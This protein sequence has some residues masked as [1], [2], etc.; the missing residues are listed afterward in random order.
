[1]TQ[2]MVSAE[3]LRILESL[4][5]ALETIVLSYEEF[6][7]DTGW[8]HTEDSPMAADLKSLKRK[9]GPGGDWQGD[10]LNH[11][12]TSAMVFLVVQEQHIQALAA[13][14]RQ[15]LV[16]FS[17]API[18]RSVL[19]LSGRVAWLLDTRIDSRTRAARGFLGQIED[20]T[21]A[22]RTAYALDM[23]HASKF[24]QRLHDVRK[25]TAPARFD[26]SEIETMKDGVM[27]IRKQR[28]PGLR[29]SLRINEEVHQNPWNAGGMYDYLSNATH[30][31]LYTALEMFSVD[32]QTSS[33]RM[34]SLHLENMILPYR[35][36]R[37]SAQA[38]LDTWALHAAYTGLDV[39]LP[40]LLGRELDE[41]PKPPG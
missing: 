25:V 28:L 27:L 4:A 33:G 38:F 23:K 10:E 12:L 22:K 29:D 3:A 7:N 24:G 40:R 11:A 41:L 37:T 19:E 1:M 13:L 18:A 31:T 32:G 17:I 35:L 20:A 30:P 39:E 15:Q 36:C 34:T 6:A 16:F 5:Q 14:L 2:P 8:H 9:F 26:E 21:K